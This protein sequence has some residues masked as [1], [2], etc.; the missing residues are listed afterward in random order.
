MTVSEPAKPGRYEMYP[1]R[2]KR[3][4][5]DTELLTSEAGEF[6]VAD[7][8]TVARILAGDILEDSALYRELTARQI[9]YDAESVGLLDL[10]A[11]KIKTKKAFL[12]SGPALH[13]VVLTLRCNQ[14]CRYCQASSRKQ[15]DAK[16]DMSDATIGKT[17]EMI[18]QSRS[19]NV[20]VEIQ[21]GEPL[22]CFDKVRTIVGLSRTQAQLCSKQVSFVLC[23]NLTLATDEVL[24][25]C[26]Q[27]NISISTSLDGP[28]AIHNRNRGAGWDDNYG[29]FRERLCRAFDIVGS[30]AVSALTT[31]APPCLDSPI[32]IINEFVDIGL[33]SVFLRRVTHVGRATCWSDTRQAYSDQFLKFYLRA[34]DYAIELN[35]K[36]VEIAEAYASL[37]LHKMLTPFPAGFVNLQSPAGAGIGV[38]TYHYN[39]DVYAQDEGRML[40]EMGD[41]TFRLGNVHSDSYTAVIA[42]P[43]LQ[44]LLR[45]TC[46]EITPG[47]SDCAYLPYCGCDPVQEYTSHG[48]VSVSRPLSEHCRFH[49]AVFDYLFQRY[50][51]GDDLTRRIFMSWALNRPVSLGNAK[52]A[53]RCTV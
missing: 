8:G 47:C 21:G 38:L 26:K 11:V 13:I 1:F 41:F 31:I 34:L 44:S 50:L 14:V 35:R 23:T 43:R 20:T 28:R 45:D 6:V 48:V 32:D 51:R 12:L 9:I 42:N 27:E 5:R 30:D 24:Q 39:G 46:N 52:G 10:L 17:V 22:V 49:M 25:F 15:D 53:G 29:R 7:R 37:L 16:Y 3:L 2:F 40:A 18:M 4:D 36:G 19:D 33:K